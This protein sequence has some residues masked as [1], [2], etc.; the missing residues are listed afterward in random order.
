[1]FKS[2]KVSTT[3]PFFEFPGLLAGEYIV[4]CHSPLSKK[5]HLIESPEVVVDL[6]QGHAHANLSFHAE[7]RQIDD[8]G[9][10][11]SVLSLLVGL[12]IFGSV[13]FHNE[14]GEYIRSFRSKAKAVMKSASTPSTTSLVSI[15]EKKSQYVTNDG[16]NHNNSQG[17]KK[18]KRRTR[19][20]PK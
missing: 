10:A 16:E 8:K 13:V 19:R 4:K 20:K 1:M 11:G 18:L 6:S 2:T 5:T 9:A 7:M 15:S 12:L 3:L 17:G 14:V